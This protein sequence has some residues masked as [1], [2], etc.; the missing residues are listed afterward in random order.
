MYI[1]IIW[2]LQHTPPRYKLVSALRVGH[3]LIYTTHAFSRRC[4]YKSQSRIPDYSN[5][6]DLLFNLKEVF[7]G[8][9]R[10]KT[11]HKHLP[12]VYT[13]DGRISLGALAP[14]GLKQ[15]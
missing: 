5:D 12:Y 4:T 6:Y 7:V 2:C 3:Y 8:V 1:I 13:Q 11:L 14:L 10:C 15:G 9:V